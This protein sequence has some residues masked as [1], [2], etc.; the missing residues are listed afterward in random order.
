[1]GEHRCWHGCVLRPV[2]NRDVLWCVGGCWVPAAWV[3]QRQPLV[4]IEGLLKKEGV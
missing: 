1:M 2:W 3:F 4:Q